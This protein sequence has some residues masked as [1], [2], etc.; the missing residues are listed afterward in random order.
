MRYLF[1]KLNEI[2]NI[3]NNNEDSKISEIEKVNQSQSEDITNCMIAN[4]EIFETVLNLSTQVENLTSKSSEQTS[5]SNDKT[6][7]ESNNKE[8]V[9]EEQKDIKN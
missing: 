6:E 8:K 5:V 4:S 7:I 3:L 1:D 2:N 9:S